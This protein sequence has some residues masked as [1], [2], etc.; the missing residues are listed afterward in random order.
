MFTNLFQKKAGLK[1]GWLKFGIILL[2]SAVN[3]WLLSIWLDQNLDPSYKNKID[4]LA[5]D[6]PEIKYLQNNQLNFTGLSKYFTALAEKRGGEYAY[7]ILRAAPI[8]P[9]TDMHLLGHVV[10]DVL[11]KQKGAAGIKVCTNE[12]R[13]SCSHSIVVG[14]FFDKGETALTEIADVCRRAPGGPGAY[15][16]CFHGLGHGILAYTGYDMAKTTE[17]CQKTTTP[18]YNNREAIECI[19]GTVMEIIGGGF[20]D[21]A[22]WE[23]QSQKYLSSKDPLAL[24]K[25]NV[26]PLDAKAQCYVY[27]TPHLFKMAGSNLGNPTAA[28]YEKAFRFCNE[29]PN[30]DLGNRSACYGGFGKEF[31]VLAQE[32][33]IRKINQASEEQLK[34][35][36]EWCLLARDTT[37]IQSC[38]S[39]AMGSLYWGGENDIN[40]AIRFCRAASDINYQKSCFQELTG[41][42]IF[43]KKGSSDL[44]NFCSL[45]P[46]NYRAECYDRI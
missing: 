18:E 36:Y 31:V 8:P 14:L 4:K 30:D 17:L 3:I 23:K 13:N 42:V 28:D 1:P 44:S 24:C 11:Y 6:Y 5:L 26:I 38:I 29:L 10:G 35:I 33:D 46:D 41:A 19:G 32:R 37:G 39:Y 15:T 7:E 45:L 20:H 22:L 27:L 16:M 34:K 40:S 9:Q 25:S 43:Y 21:P 2:L 12:F